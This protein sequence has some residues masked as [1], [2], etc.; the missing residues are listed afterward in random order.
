MNMLRKSL[1]A[2][3]AVFSLAPTAVFAYP[4]Q[5]D[6]ICFSETASC[7]TLCYFGIY[8]QTTC[9]EAGYCYA[10]S[11]ASTESTTSV[12]EAAEDAAP[13]C[14]SAHPDETRTT[15]AEG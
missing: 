14:D 12:T 9:G 15:T 13:V 5:C 2:V 10:P 6:E 11:S 1:L 7:G 3:T 4:P 8:E